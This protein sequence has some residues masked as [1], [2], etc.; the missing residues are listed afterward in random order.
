MRG[1]PLETTRIGGQTVPAQRKSVHT[2]VILPLR[3]SLF[4]KSFPNSF[5]RATVRTSSQNKPLTMSVV[6]VQCLD[7]VN[8]F[9]V[10]PYW[11]PL[12]AYYHVIVLKLEGGRIYVGRTQNRSARLR[13]LLNQDDYAPKFVKAYRP[14]RVIKI[15]RVW[16]YIPAEQLKNDLTAYYSRIY[17]A[18]YVRGGDYVALAPA[19]DWI[20]RQQSKSNSATMDRW[21][22]MR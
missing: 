22:R 18:F 17:G 1:K 4:L 9:P 12:N 20:Q 5:R 21:I 8:D 14:I 11:A 2:V 6:T 19:D 13:S 3:R 7:Y 16:G 15:Y 10:F